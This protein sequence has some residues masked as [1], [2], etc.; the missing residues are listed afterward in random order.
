MEMNAPGKAAGPNLTEWPLYA[1]PPTQ[2]E[3][4]FLDENGAPAT[5]T[6]QQPLARTCGGGYV[7]RLDRPLRP[8]PNPPAPAGPGA[9]PAASGG[10][11]QPAA[12]PP[13]AAPAG[14]GGA[15]AASMASAPEAEC[16]QTVGELLG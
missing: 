10:P 14:S 9:A 7:Y 15:V 2:Q 4:Q 6:T 11:G 1:Q 8:S 3:L 12:G 5:V 16:K 13:A